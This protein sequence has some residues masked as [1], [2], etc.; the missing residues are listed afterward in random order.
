MR[1]DIVT[2]HGHTKK[3]SRYEKKQIRMH[4]QDHDKIA[5]D[6]IVKTLNHF[7]AITPSQTYC[8]T[9][10]VPSFPSIAASSPSS[11]PGSA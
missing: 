6:D 8:P 4:R 7:V 2:R 9:A 10:E 11:S 1:I 3:P 5:L